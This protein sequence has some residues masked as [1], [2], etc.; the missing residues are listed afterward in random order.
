M[1]FLPR[2]PKR[3]VPTRRSKFLSRL[4]QEPRSMRMPTKKKCSMWSEDIYDFRLATQLRNMAQEVW[5][6]R[7]KNVPHLFANIGNEEAV[8]IVIARPGGIEKF[9]FEVGTEIGATDAPGYSSAGRNRK[10]FGSC[11]CIRNHSVSASRIDARLSRSSEPI[12]RS[13]PLS[14]EG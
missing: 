11:A 9:F 12:R 5:F 13:G 10:D 4:A 6:T 14:L 1:W 7:A 8:V 2:L 3:T